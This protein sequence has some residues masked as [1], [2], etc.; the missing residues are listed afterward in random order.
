MIICHASECI[1][2]CHQLPSEITKNI[3]N[4]FM[5]YSRTDVIRERPAILTAFL[6]YGKISR[7]K[8]CKTSRTCQ[9]YTCATSSTNLN[10]EEMTSQ[11]IMNCGV[12]N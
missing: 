7:K 6:P 5:Q 11:T 10:D 4:R 3:T 12:T 2:R 1:N 9:D 8:I